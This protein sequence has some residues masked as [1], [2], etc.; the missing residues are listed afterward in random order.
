MNTIFI[1]IASYR[2]AELIAT[3]KDALEQAHSPESLSFGVCWQYQSEEELHYIESLKNIKNCRLKTFL[4]SE[5]K[6]VG[7]ARY[8]TDK[9]WQGEKFIFKIDS[10][11]RFVRDWDMKLINMLNLCPSEK[12]ILSAYPPAYKPPRN[13]L[14]NF[15]TGI[16]FVN[17]SQ[18]G[19]VTLKGSGEDLSQ[20]SS[21]KLGAF[22]AAGFIF[23]EASI[24]REVPSDPNIYFE[25]EEFLTSV[26]AWTRGWDIY[27][28]HQVICWHYY[29]DNFVRPLH[30]EDNEWA[31]LNYLSEKRFR[32]I[33]GIETSSENFGVYGLG[34][35][36]TLSA[37]LEMSDLSLAGNS[38]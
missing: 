20:Y 12:P 4:A 17:Q 24:I 5:S 16:K 14:N 1:K 10:H 38:L 25:G 8:Q 33:I 19:I 31:H 34:Q 23:S 28:P 32:Q 26:R 37:F 11:M 7:W 36:R 22:I 21:P 18:S 27:H 3:I 2:D 15:I 6:G 9:L 13:L 30:W 35:N 29:N